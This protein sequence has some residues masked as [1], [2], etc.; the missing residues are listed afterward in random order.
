MQIFHIAEAARWQAAQLSGSYAQ[1]TLGRTLDEEGFLHAARAD[2]WE[3]VRRRYYAGVQEPLVLIVIDTDELTAPWQED[4]VGDTTY[5]H[6]YGPLNLSAVVAT[7]PLGADSTA[8]TEGVQ[9]AAAPAPPGR[10]FFQEFVGEMSF[11]MF[12]AVATMAFAFLCAVVGTVASDDVGGLV[13][14][15]V[16]LAVGVAV[17]V[18][19]SRR[20]AAH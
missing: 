7:V 16:G 20:R 1:S 4:V 19:V 11:R 12:A 17:W 14:L 18:V 15:L 10:T 3:D 5:P 2:Q 6:I 8:P 9:R 13:G